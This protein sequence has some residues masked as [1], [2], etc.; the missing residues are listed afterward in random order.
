MVVAMG[1][2]S[3]C[4]QS[5]AAGQIAVGVISEKPAF[6]MNKDSDGQAIALRG[7]VPVRVIGPINKGQTVIAST[8]GRAIYGMVNPIAIALE[9]SMDFHE[10]LVECVIL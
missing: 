1:G 4:T 5:F 3:E 10:K 6:L 2:D 7:R 8:D 9:T